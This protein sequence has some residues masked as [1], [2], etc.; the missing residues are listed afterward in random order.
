RLRDRPPG[1]RGRGEWRRSGGAKS[2]DELFFF[3]EPTPTIE[4][5]AV[6]EPQDLGGAGDGV[7]A[8]GVGGLSRRAGIVG[9]HEGK[10]ALHARRGGEPRPKCCTSRRSGDPVLRRLMRDARKFEFLDLAL[11]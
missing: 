6:E 4:A 11:L 8:D 7:E 9:E 5:F 10:L 3:R 1:R 2:A